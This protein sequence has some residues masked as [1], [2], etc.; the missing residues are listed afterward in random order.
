MRG[1]T[2]DIGG[3]QGAITGGVLHGLGEAASAAGTFSAETA[4]HVAGHGVVGGAANIAMGGKFGDGFLSAAV[5]AAA[6]NAGLFGAQ[7]GGLAGVARRT[8]MAGVVGGTAS[9]I[10]GGKF[11]NGAYTAAFQHLLNAELPRARLLQHAEDLLSVA[12]SENGVSEIKGSAH[13]AR[14]LEYHASTSLNAR[15]DETPWCSSF[16]NWVAERV[17]LQGTNSA[18]ASSWKSWGRGI[19]GPVQGAVAVFRHPDGT[20]HVG[21]V[22]GVTNSGKIVVFGGNQS[23]QARYSFYDPLSPS[24]KLVAYRVPNLP[25]RALI[26]PRTFTEGRSTGGSTR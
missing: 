26:V 21:F 3:V 6:G 1:L 20:G 12:E 5:G 15:S 25:N 14:I 7:G 8:I 23:N 13:N 22:A 2:P 17:G 9:V 19:D 18:S 24:M 10:G 11:A 16:V 4:L